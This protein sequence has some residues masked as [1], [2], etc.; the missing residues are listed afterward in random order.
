[1]L[2]KLE[3]EYAHLQAE[4][5]DRNLYNF[6]VTANH[7]KVYLKNTMAVDQ[8]VRDT[9]AS[10]QDIR[11]CMDLCDKAKH[12][13]LSTRP[14]P[15]TWTWSGEIGGAPVGE[16]EIGSGDKRVMFSGSRLIEVD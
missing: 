2:K 16:L 11:D 13:T 5:S 4:S 9:F 12:H 10:D 6:V 1:M 15:T 3:H 14:N 7:L 8:I